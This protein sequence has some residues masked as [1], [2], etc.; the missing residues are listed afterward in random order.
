MN[1]KYNISR[2]CESVRLKCA[3]ELLLIDRDKEWTCHII[4]YV[5]VKTAVK[6]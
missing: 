6:I 1:I 3:T 4:S 5:V 2:V